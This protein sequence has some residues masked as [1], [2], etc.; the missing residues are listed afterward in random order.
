[1]NEAHDDIRAL[2]ASD[3]ERLTPDHRRTVEEHLPECAD[4]AAF[5]DDVMFLREQIRE[6]G[7]AMFEPHPEPSSL[8]NYARR[9]D[10]PESRIGR[11][12]RI[13]ATCRLEVEAHRSRQAGTASAPLRRGGGAWGVR[14]GVATAAAALLGL[15]AGWRFHAS[16]APGPT[17]SSIPGPATGTGV[18]DTHDSGSIPPA[19][20]PST[21]GAAMV[22]PAPVLHLLP[23][24]LRDEQ[25]PMQR[26]TLDAGETALAV[27]VPIALPVSASDSDRFTFE[28][29]GPDAQPVWSQEMTVAT[30]RKHL[31]SAEVVNLIL[32]LPRP[33]AAGE[34]EFRVA[35]AG[36]APAAGRTLYRAGIT[37][38][39]RQS[40]AATKPPQ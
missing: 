26:W 34:Y 29:R 39:Y 10:E 2:I 8:G 27:A 15:V 38:A 17:P 31:E 11:H 9:R 6:G 28:M 4:C 32:A 13:C 18:G 24:L 12:L 30:I 14:L 7:E 23:G 36:G 20:T 5:A 40:P 33:L 3:P 37:I 16:F 19:G 22:V 35:P 1:M 25:P 21:P